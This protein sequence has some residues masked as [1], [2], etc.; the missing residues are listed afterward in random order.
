[1]LRDDPEVGPGK[2][3][4]L[5]RFGVARHQSSRWQRIASLPEGEFDAYFRMLFSSFPSA[6]LVLA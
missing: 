3:D 2:G 6:P 5:S 4:T 1:M